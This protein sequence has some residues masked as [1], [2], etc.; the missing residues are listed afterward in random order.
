MDRTIA[1]DWD[2]HWTDIAS[3]TEAGPAPKYR[4]RL[5][6]D[7]LA[8]EGLPAN[9][10]VLDIGSG[11]GDFVAAFHSRYP[12][13]DVAGIELSRA[14]VMAGSRKVPK[15]RFYQRDLLVPVNATD[16]VGISATHA[17]C[18]EVIEH[19]DD[20]QILLQNASR[21]LAP[22]CL[23]IA[24]VPGGPTSEFYKHIGHRRH[25][26][27]RELSEVLEKAGFT[28]ERV[29]APGFPFF[30]LFRLLVTLRGKRLIEDVSVAVSESPIHVRVGN[31]LFD[32]L[33][34]LNLSFWGWQT[35]VIARW[36]GGRTTGN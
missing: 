32:A 6:L 4:S 8:R 3:T 34:R 17:V 22:N 24:T 18:S 5:I 36:G 28:V 20:P 21:Y 30:N 19:L 12:Q 14:G 29:I 13:I 15:A 10:Q 16:T 2:K 25:Y 33:F 9:A 26:R 7:L 35:I 23:F 1:D 11:L 31:I 27:P